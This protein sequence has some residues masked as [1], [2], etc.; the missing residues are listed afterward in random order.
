VAQ[1]NN[2]AERGLRCVAAVLTSRD[3]DQAG[4]RKLCDVDPPTWRADVLARLSDH[5]TRRILVLLPCN[6]KAVSSWWRREEQDR[7]AARS[8]AR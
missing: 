2:T 6:W 3:S 1:I 4:R 5:S 8:P 7:T